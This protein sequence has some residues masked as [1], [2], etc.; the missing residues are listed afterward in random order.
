MKAVLGL[1][2]LAVPLLA[3]T[4]ARR[5][6]AGKNH[7]TATSS[8][9]ATKA[10]IAALRQLIKQQHQQ[11]L[12][13][14]QSLQ[15]RDAQLQQTQQ[16]VNALQNP[17]ADPHIKARVA[18]APATQSDDT[19]SKLE[20]DLRDLKLT[21]KNAATSTEEDQK[22]MVALEGMVN[23]FRFGGDVRVRGEGFFQKYDGCPTGT[24]EDRERARIR[25]R[26]GVEG[27]LNEDFT[28]G[29]YLATGLWAGGAPS[30]TDPI[31][32]NETL[33]G[34]FERKTIGLDRAW[35]TYQPLNHKWIKLTGGKFA[36]DW[37]R[38]NYMFDPD[39]NP[40]GFSEKFSFDLS[41]TAILKN[42]TLQGIQLLINEATKGRDAKAIGGQFLTKWQPTSIWTI[43]P[44]FTLLDWSNVDVIANAAL[45]L[46]VCKTAVTVGC[47]PQAITTDTGSV[48]NPPTV[49]PSVVL[50]NG[51]TNSTTVIGIGAKQSRAFA[52]RFT[53]ADLIV[54][55]VITTPSKRFPLHLLG[56]YEKNLRA[57]HHRDSMYVA[58]LEVGQ[59]NDKHD[60]LFGYVFNRTDQDAVISS[61]AES[62]ARS[63]T[64]VIQHKFYLNWMVMKN[65][66]ATFTLWHGRVQDATLQNSPIFGAPFEPATMKDPWLNRLQFDMVY[67]F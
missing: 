38:T 53:N 39:L 29:L 52:S 18:D 62:D 43:T 41:R 27:K 23:R 28:G 26:F 9:A 16:Q 13:L 45:P 11:M 60:L 48:I 57:A 55:N 20:T 49:P 32:T 36:Y 4:S 47:L 61:F 59:Q 14:E 66:Q 46:A 21:Q 58:M 6:M 63:P 54:E 10:D 5:P 31:S 65:T 19:V 67:R 50:A 24:C 12:R 25:A 40:E 42:V 3:Q 33:T 64:N 44:S 7:L 37:H 22:R 15:E 2:L 30:F 35:V 1:A 17:A 56:E 8:S 51:I 34:F